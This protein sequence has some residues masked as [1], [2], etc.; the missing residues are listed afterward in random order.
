MWS[1]PRFEIISGTL[2]A[3]PA[4]RMTANGDDEGQLRRAREIKKVTGAQNDHYK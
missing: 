2:R 1:V 4:L 3:N